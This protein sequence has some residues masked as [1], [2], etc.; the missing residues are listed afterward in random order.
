MDTQPEEI[1]DII[2]YWTLVTI[3]D[4]WH[5]NILRRVSK[6]WRRVFDKLERQRFLATVQSNTKYSRY[7]M[8]TVLELLL[9][10]DK[11]W[12]LFKLPFA[13]DDVSDSV[14]KI[15][16]STHCQLK[17]FSITRQPSFIDQDYFIIHIDGIM[18]EWTTKFYSIKKWLIDNG[19]DLSAL[20][21]HNLAINVCGLRRLIYIMM[22]KKTSGATFYSVTRPGHTDISKTV[23]DVGSVWAVPKIH[24]KTTDDYVRCEYKLSDLNNHIQC[25]AVTDMVFLLFKTY[26]VDT[27]TMF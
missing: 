5:P 12:T 18:T 25:K 13:G 21:I 22:N 6:R 9:C 20:D 3:S 24:Q 16:D 2:V 23:N 1:L 15:R 27:K 10:Q 4:Y 7:I 14:K 8:A 17:G 26:N 11:N 19:I